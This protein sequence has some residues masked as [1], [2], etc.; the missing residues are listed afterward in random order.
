MQFFEFYQAFFITSSVTKLLGYLM[1]FIE[2][3][4][5][6]KL[7]LSNNSSFDTVNKRM[8]LKYDL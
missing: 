4:T 6:M 8:Q 1:C 2:L 5:T 7:I 3:Y